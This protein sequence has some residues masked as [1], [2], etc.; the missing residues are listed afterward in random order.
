MS[1]RTLTTGL[2][3]LYAPT[4]FIAIGFVLV[5]F[6]ISMNWD[7]AGRTTTPF[8]C[9]IERWARLRAHTELVLVRLVS[10]GSCRIK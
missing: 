8:I 2:I 1:S 10:S 6:E 3:F 7:Q 5:L 4:V 9:P